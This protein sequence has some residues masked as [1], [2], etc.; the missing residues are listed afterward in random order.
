MIKGCYNNTTKNGQSAISKLWTFRKNVLLLSIID[1]VFDKLLVFENI[2][3]ASNMES[4]T[5]KHFSTDGLNASIRISKIDAQQKS[6]LIKNS[7]FY[8]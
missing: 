2:F 8:F 4:S 5:I 1:W 7:E 3:E 6:Y